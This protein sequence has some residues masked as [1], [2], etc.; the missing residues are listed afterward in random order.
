MRTYLQWSTSVHR[1]LYGERALGEL[2]Q[3]AVYSTKCMGKEKALYVSEAME[4]RIQRAGGL[5][6]LIMRLA[7]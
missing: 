6:G 1:V 4:Q 7:R 5:N 3:I 2:A